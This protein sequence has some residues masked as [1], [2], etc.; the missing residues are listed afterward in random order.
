MLLKA[1]LAASSNSPSNAAPTAAITIMQ[2]ASNW[3][4]TTVFHA[5]LITDG[6]PKKTEIIPAYLQYCLYQMRKKKYSNLVTLHN[7]FIHH[8]R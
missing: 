1:F 6:R 2:L 8:L 5:F 4:R 3:H 7:L